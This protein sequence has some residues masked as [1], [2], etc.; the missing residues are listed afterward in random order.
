MNRTVSGC[1]L[2]PCDIVPQNEQARGFQAEDIIDAARIFVEIYLDNTGR[3]VQK[4]MLNRSWC[5]GCQ[6]RGY[7]RFGKES[8]DI[9]NAL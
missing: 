9:K 7:C 2:N 1:D 6:R 5:F 8:S 4:S 3:T